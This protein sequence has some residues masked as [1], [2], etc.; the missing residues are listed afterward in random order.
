MTRL[1]SLISEIDLIFANFICIIGG[2]LHIELQIVVDT[3]KAYFSFVFCGLEETFIF[4]D[5]INTNKF[6]FNFTGL[7]VDGRLL[8]LYFWT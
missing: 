1:I 7:S 3:G 8:S 4:S 6:I 5:E 2:G